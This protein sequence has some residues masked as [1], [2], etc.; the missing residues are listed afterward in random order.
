MEPVEGEET[1]IR[2]VLP[3]IVDPG[4]LTDDTI[5][6]E[7]R[8]FADVPAE[9]LRELQEP[10]ALVEPPS[11]WVEPPRTATPPPRPPAP[12]VETFHRFRINTH[13]PVSLDTPALVGRKPVAPR[14]S[15]GKPPRLVRV[16]S[17]LHEVSSTHLELRQHGNSVV[18]TDLKSTNGTLVTIPGATTQKLRQGE[19]VV[20]S[21]GTLVD[22]GDGNILEILPVPRIVSSNP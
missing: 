12:V 2:P 3:S 20:V 5:I 10:P 7:R 18:V 11:G 13:E 8:P 19:S 21:S 4:I 9:A 14:I 1:V 17:P 16:S 22:I 6:R 15:T